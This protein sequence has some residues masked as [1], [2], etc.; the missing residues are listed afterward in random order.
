[1]R[2]R[3]FVTLASLTAIG[4]VGWF[5][6]VP[7][8]EPLGANGGTFLPLVD[9]DGDGLDDALEARLR[10]APDRVDTD[11]D[12]LTDL[13]E[14]LLGRDPLVDEGT[15][16]DPVPSLYGDVYA[17]GAEVYVQVFALFQ[18]TAG[19][20]EAAWAMP[21]RMLLMPG[22][23]LR[24]LLAESGALAPSSFPQWNMVSVTFRLPRRPLDREAASSLGFAAAVD[25]EIL[26]FQIPLIHVDGYLSQLRGLSKLLS[27]SSG[28]MA[29]TGSSQPW[30][31]AETEP[32]GE[33]NF[34]GGSVEPAE[35]GDGGPPPSAGDPDQ[36]CYQI[37]Q[38]VATL[39]GGRVLYQVADAYCEAL[40]GAVCF[41]GCAATVG[42]TVIVIDIVGL[43][44]G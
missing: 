10:T 7:A 26:G 5:L 41:S 22:R 29:S 32:G 36:V 42:E 9:N 4:L 23:T 27:S 3:A 35:P 1:M 40:P 37:L 21:D 8:A 38:P 17:L 30:S 19:K 43:I 24:G 14:L 6:L 13:E 20:L 15:T 12:S 44:G 33:P 2:A 39:P 11:G 34:P 18:R 25:R 31:G 16:S 28:G